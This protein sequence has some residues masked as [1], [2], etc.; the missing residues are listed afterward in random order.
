M[1]AA[2]PV[3]SFLLLSR[4]R[5]IPPCAPDMTIRREHGVFRKPL[6]VGQISISAARR[7]VRNPLVS[8]KMPGG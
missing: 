2:T 3:F 7:R 4:D 6:N 1:L 5:Q 8:L